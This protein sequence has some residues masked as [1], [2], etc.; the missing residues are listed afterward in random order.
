MISNL[1]LFFVITATLVSCDKQETS[2]DSESGTEAKSRNKRVERSETLSIRSR[3]QA[4]LEAA[5]QIESSDAREK[6]IAEV[7]WNALELIPEIFVEAIEELPADS[8]EKARLIQTYVIGL[9]KSSPEEALAWADSLADGETTALAREQVAL[10]L[11]ES[12]PERAINLLPD[13]AFE[14]AEIAPASVEVL[15]LW[16]KSTPA[17]AADWAAALP[18]VEARIAG[19]KAVMAQWVETDAA[20]AVTWVLSHTDAVLRQESVDIITELF[21]SQPQPVRDAILENADMSLRSEIQRRIDQIDAVP[22]PALEFELESEPN[23][24]SGVP[25]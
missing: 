15:Q 4:S 24:N 20:A 18:S 12:E 9:I 23:A 10:I 14:D 5:K 25:K 1:V 16:T 19:I 22:G 3:L 6:A 11:A 2:S 17:K 13:S 8:P 21:F 7:A